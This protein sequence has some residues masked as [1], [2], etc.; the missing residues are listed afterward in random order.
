MFLLSPT[1]FPFDLAILLLLAGSLGVLCAVVFGCRGARLE[2]TTRWIVGTLSLLVF[3]VVAY[4]SFLE[5]RTLVTDA[6]SVPFP[7][8]EPL[9]IAVLSDI[10]VG[11]YKGAAFLERA[12]K[13]V[14]A[15]RPDLVFLLGDYVFS[16]SYSLDDLRPLA[17]LRPS[18][19]TYAVL[20]NYD[21]D[22]TP[23]SFRVLPELLTLLAQ[24]KITVL[25]DSHDLVQT[26]TD[27]FAIAGIKDLQTERANLGAALRGIP[28]DLPVILLSHNPDVILD[29]RSRRAALILSGHTHGGQVR[30]PFLGPLPPLP[31]TIGRQYDQGIF[32]LESGT[33]LA[34]TR[35]I[36]ESAARTR[37]LAWPEVLVLHT[38]P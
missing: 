4:S 27:S 22:P 11:P 19:G 28:A 35:G 32:P 1:I 9:T 37:L 8:K 14:N 31:T 29:A 34:I 30:L 33:T 36:G 20:G 25:Q 10:H 38:M 12:V 6:A 26:S 17:Q 15:E 16:D 7:T 13:R 2:R 23:G 18:I 3:L 24:M 21:R 5:P